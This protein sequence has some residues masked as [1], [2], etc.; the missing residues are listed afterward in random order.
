MLQIA[1]RRPG[2]VSHPQ[3]PKCLWTTVPL[4]PCACFS[5]SPMHLH[6]TCTRCGHG[7][8]RHHVAR[9][10]VYES[11]LIASQ[12]SWMARR[13]RQHPLHKVGIITR[14]M[15]LIHLSNIDSTWSTNQFQT[16]VCNYCTNYSINRVLNNQLYNCINGLMKELL[17]WIIQSPYIVWKCIYCK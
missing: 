9:R 2:S 12:K 4:F 5:S 11:H 8:H 14:M 6:G 17:H 13:L 16:K 15:S 3:N 10:W 1:W 7:H